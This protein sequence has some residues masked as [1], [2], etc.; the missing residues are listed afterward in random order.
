MDTKQDI[1]IISDREYKQ[2]QQFFHC[3]ILNSFYSCNTEHGLDS[4]R[5][6]LETAT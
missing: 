2:F 4:A 3:Y 6:P 1:V 5:Q